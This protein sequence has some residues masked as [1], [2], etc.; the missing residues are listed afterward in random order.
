M[1]IE[2]YR[3]SNP[4]MVIGNEETRL[5][6]IKWLKIW[7]KKNKPALLLGPPGIGKTSLVHTV[8]KDLGYEVLEL[9]AS[10]VRTKT[11][12]DKRL[13]PS[14]LNSTLFEEKILIFLDEVDGIYGNQDRGGIE[15]LFNL[16][17]N[18][19]NPIVMV[20]NI[21]ENKKMVKLMKSAQ[22]FR[23]KRIP[24]KLIEMIV[25]NILRR[26]NLTIN[27]ENLEIIVRNS[28]G[29]IRAAVNSAQVS[30]SGTDDFISEIR[31]TQ[32]SQIESL[33]IFFNSSSR[34]EAY[35]ALNCCKMQP[36]EKIRVIFQSI[37]SSGLKGK[38]LIEVMEE[39]SKADE[40]VSKIDRT[41]NW[42]LLRY[43]DQILA[44]SLFN[45]IK[46]EKI[47]YGKQ[48]VPWNLQLRLWNDR[49]HLKYISSQLAK[50]HHV[51]AKDAVLFYLPYVVLISHLKNNEKHF[52]DRLRLDE[53]AL[54]IFKKEAQK[55][56]LEAKK[57]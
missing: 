45:A 10:D 26:E 33:K 25:K 55:V 14:T 41:K 15:F 31:D 30:S 47:M 11:M 28:N 44:G 46:G 34:K 12:L 48:S 56:S 5:N 39:I 1:W 52:S 20:A 24:P 18:S 22:V 36:K 3:P 37:L 38:K 57:I 9:N 8:A 19:R 13:G 7:K 4:N 21:E 23:F 6:F 49:V 53:S 29:D 50:Q 40:L 27:Q 43:F 2:K 54:K 16:I 32:I 42:I 51:S 35:L 17:K